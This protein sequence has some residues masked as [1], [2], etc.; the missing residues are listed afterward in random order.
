MLMRPVELLHASRR[1][2]CLPSSCDMAGCDCVRCFC[3]LTLQAT[4]A[5]ASVAACVNAY[6]LTT[7]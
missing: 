4:L 7:R 2:V 6:P 5:A 3:G 1:A